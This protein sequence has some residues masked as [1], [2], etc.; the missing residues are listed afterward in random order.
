MRISVT[1]T[2]GCG[3]TTVSKPVAERLGLEYVD[4][5]GFAIRE[6]FVTGRERGSY[7]VDEKKIKRK[8]ATID[9]C[10]FDWHY[11]E[12]LGADYVFVLRLNPRL[13][14]K[15]L[16]Q[17][18]YS[19]RKLKENLMAE[20]L[21]VCLASAL[22]HNPAQNVFEIMNTNSKKTASTIVKIVEGDDRKE[23][24]RKKSI[25]NFLSERNLEWLENV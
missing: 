13:L 1:G 7:I 3:K 25:C 5:G 12:I 2:P 11:S 20:M 18:R 21:D 19:K 14:F 16:S 24:F 23:F 4:V 9:D 15:R 6:G 17:R 10:I 8:L 22:A